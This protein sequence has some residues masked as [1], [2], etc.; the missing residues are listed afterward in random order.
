MKVVVSLVD[1]ARL[2]SAGEGFLALAKLS[3]R[4]LTAE[5]LLL[6]DL[7]EPRCSCVW[8]ESVW[9]VTAW[10]ATEPAAKLWS[11]NA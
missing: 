2:G 11:A 8:L 1:G 9:S 3:V 6:A 5:L 10:R 4:E 7:Q